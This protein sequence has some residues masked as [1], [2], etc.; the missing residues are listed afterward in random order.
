MA[1]PARLVRLEKSMEE[2]RQ[3]ASALQ[4]QDAAEC[5]LSPLQLLLFGGV[6]NYNYCFFGAVP[7]TVIAFLGCESLGLGVGCLGCK[8]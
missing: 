8:V 1:T 3:T 7:I 6:P 2:L 4:V 5:L